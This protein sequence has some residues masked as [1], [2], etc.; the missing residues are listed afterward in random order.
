MWEY[1]PS[2]N[3]W[4]GKAP[5]PGVGRMYATGFAIGGKGYIGTG[6]AGLSGLLSE[7]W[8]YDPVADSWLQKANFP[9]GPRQE[10]SGIAIGNF[11]Y[12]GLGSSQGTYLFDW[13]QYDPTNDTW[14]LK[15]PFLGGPT[16]EATQFAIGTSGFIGT[17]YNGIAS[18]VMKKDFWEYRPDSTTS[19]SEISAAEAQIIMNASNASLTV[20]FEN[21]SGLPVNIQLF[22]ASAKLVAEFKNAQFPLV[23]STSGLTD[24]VYLVT[25]NNIKSNIWSKKILVKNL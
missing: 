12:L 16:E 25:A 5:L 11:G 3:S 9:G 20:N 23:F 4:L 18:G 13:Y 15:A 6:T 7:F 10:A 8:Q 2:T 1:N 22:D 19:I 21:I 17:G 14:T 24:G